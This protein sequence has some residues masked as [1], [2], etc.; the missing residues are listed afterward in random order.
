MVIGEKGVIRIFLR[1]LIAIVVVTYK[2]TFK[3]GVGGNLTGPANIERRVLSLS[4][5]YCI[6][7][8]M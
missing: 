4:K 8:D 2:D 7:P 1:A 5:H 3:E 6:A